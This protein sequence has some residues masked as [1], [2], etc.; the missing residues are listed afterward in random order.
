MSVLWRETKEVMYSQLNGNINKRRRQSK[1][2]EYP[3]IQFL[4]KH[5]RPIQNSNPTLYECSLLRAFV[6]PPITA[7]PGS[8]HL[9][10]LLP[11]TCFRDRQ[12]RHANIMGVGPRPTQG[13]NTSSHHLLTQYQHPVSPCQPLCCLT[14]CTTVKRHHLGSVDL[15]LT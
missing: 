13:R 14:Q 5:Q 1:S 8:N 12:N 15:L 9:L 6:A 11:I 2:N 4:S 7:T 3:Q 10:H